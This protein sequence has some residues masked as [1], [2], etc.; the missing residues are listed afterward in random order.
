MD[1]EQIHTMKELRLPILERLPE[2]NSKNISEFVGVLL[3][4]HDKLIK[5]NTQLIKDNMH[6]RGLAEHLEKE[7]N[8]LAEQ[9]LCCTDDNRVDTCCYECRHLCA[10]TTVQDWRT[11]ARE[12]V[13]TNPA[14]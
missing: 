11:A 5:S 8:W 9:L 10:N 7:A 2:V 6:L 12:A 3:R 1:K 13:D 14:E 4:N